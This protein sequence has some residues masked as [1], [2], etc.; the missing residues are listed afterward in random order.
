MKKTAFICAAISLA[1]FAACNNAPVDKKANPK[2]FPKP[3]TV[4]ATT[5]A[6]INDDP[7]NRF[8]YTLRV[9][10][11]SD[12]KSGT[13]DV[14]VDYGPNFAEGFMSM[15]KGGED[16]KPIIRKGDGPYTYIV[17]FRLPN[18]TTFCDYYQVFSDKS[19]TKMEYIKAY[20]F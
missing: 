7:L 11:D 15:P 3:G 5:S 17:G 14:D 2:Q 18:D 19:H 12:I 16:L 20:T 10:A 8:T 13:Y 9:V 4:V 6:P 1:A